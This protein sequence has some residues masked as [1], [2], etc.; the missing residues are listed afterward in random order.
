MAAYIYCILLPLKEYQTALLGLPDEKAEKLMSDIDSKGFEFNM[1][2]KFLSD[3]A[4]NFGEPGKEPE[5]ALCLLFDD[6]G[7]AT[8]MVDWF[9][10]EEKRLSINLNITPVA[11]EFRDPETGEEVD[12]MTIGGEKA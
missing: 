9:H 7:N 11:Q 4:K 10:E 12:G 2:Q 5:G 6:G 1:K 8:K 3:D